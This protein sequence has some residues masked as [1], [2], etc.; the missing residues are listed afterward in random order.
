MRRL[1]VVA[2][3]LAL[4]FS[5]LTLA[6][7]LDPGEIHFVLFRDAIPALTD[8]RFGDSF[9]D[10]NAFVIGVEIAGD[11]RAYPLSILS[12]HEIVNDVVG[13]IPVAVTYCPLCGTGIVFDRRVGELVLTLKVS[14]RLLQNNLVMYDV[15]TSSQWSQL[16]GEAITGPLTGTK[17]RLVSSAMTTFAEWESLHPS[18]KVLAPPTPSGRYASDPYAPYYLSDETLFPIRVP[19]PTMHPKALVQGVSLNGESVAFPYEVVRMEGVVNE[20]VGGAAVVVTFQLGYV[21]VWARGD[22]TFVAASDAT[23]TDDTGGVW[24]RAAGERLD[25]SDRLEPVPSIPSFWFSWKDFHPETRV[26][27]EP[28]P[29]RGTFNSGFLISSS[30]FVFI[31][32]LIVT[33]LAARDLYRHVTR[34]SGWADPAWRSTAGMAYWSFLGVAFGLFAISDGLDSLSPFYRGAEVAMGS[35]FLVLGVHLAWQGVASRGHDLRRA[36]FGGEQARHEIEAALRE[37]GEEYEVREE[38]TRPALFRDVRR[39][40]LASGGSL[41]VDAAGNVLLARRGVPR[42]RVAI[43]RKLADESLAPLAKAARNDAL[44]AN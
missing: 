36:A 34:R 18:T 12:F 1:A 2:T 15:E 5:G 20:V 9:A 44:K 22:R 37:S 35:A 8:P 13:G 39:F 7:L 6:K 42:R 32:V 26:Y 41:A 43:L 11:A 4:A 30:F 28:T 25:G 24:T 38:G 17:L 14:G 33:G 27:G 29:Y 31:L 10:E 3:V 23:M 16:L 21:V 40:V 19:D